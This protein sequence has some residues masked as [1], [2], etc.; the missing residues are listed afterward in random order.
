MIY[1][2][3]GKNI[4]MNYAFLLGLFVGCLATGVL[5]VEAQ[6][7]HKTEVSLGP[8]GEAA[9]RML[10]SVDTTNR[11]QFF[12][13]LIVPRDV[14]V[15]DRWGDLNVSF[16]GED[17]IVLPRHF[18]ESYS[19]TVEYKT[20]SLTSKNR[21]DWFFS[22]EFYRIAE[23]DVAEFTLLLPPGA[24]L[25]SVSPSG[26]VYTEE[27]IIAADIEIDPQEPLSIIRASYS[28]SR[29]PPPETGGIWPVALLGGAI[30]AAALILWYW[31]RKKPRTT[32]VSHAPVTQRRDV[33]TDRQQDLLK[34]L[35]TTE[36]R[37]IR[38]LLKHTEGMIQKRLMADTGIPKAT[39]SRTLKKLQ[40]KHMVEIR[41]HGLTNRI[42]LSSW[43]L[44]K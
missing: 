14:V 8:T 15:Y 24:R 23:F 42:I 32:P 30:V 36:E 16:S 9:V 31:L 3:V 38:E 21:T 28:F 17:I 34:T 20:D 4:P 10:F 5:L 26:I 40:T 29:P 39:L 37:V 11:T 27:G 33:L 2:L 1:N 43:F 35:S 19:F 6:E 25:L 7:I 12:I 13:P 44:E 41:E 22:Y 18:Q